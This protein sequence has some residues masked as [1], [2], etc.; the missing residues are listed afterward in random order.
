MILTL[1]LSFQIYS[2]QISQLQ[3]DSLYTKFIQLKAPELLPQTDQPFELTLEDRKCGFGI[4]NAIKTN[5]DFFSPEQMNILNSILS[6]PFL[7]TS[8]ISP[9]GF[10]RI[11]Y[12][13]AGSNTPAY[14]S[15]WTVDQ[16]VAEVAKALDSAYR[17]EINYLGFLSP[18]SDGNGGGDDKYDVY[19]QNQGGGFYGYTEWESKI[20]SVNWTSFMVIDNDYV[21]YYSTGLN[22]MRVT[23]AHEF[24]HSIQL[25]N[26][27]IFNDTNPFRSSDTYFYELTSTSMEEFVYDDVN[28]YYA[29]MSSYFN[30]TDLAFPGQ[31]GYNI[32]IW[33]IYLKDNFG[34][35]LLKR[36]WEL[37]P[38]I[39]AILA[40]NQS[41]N[42]LSTSF[43]RE[44]NKFGI[45]TYFTNFRRIPGKYFEEA[46][47]Y[48]IVIPKFNVQFPSPLLN[49]Q[50]KPTT[51]NFVRFNIPANNDTLVAVVTNADAFAANDNS[52]QLF[53]F[54]YTLYSDPNTGQRDLTEEYSSTFSVSNP[55]FWS[56]SEILNNVLVRQDTSQ[57]PIITS[58]ESFAF[59][60]PFNYLNSIY[61][62]GIFISFFATVGDELDF[63]VYSVGLEKVYSSNMRAT[64]RQTPSGTNYV[65]V[66]WNG[67]DNN[68][69]KLAS[70]VYIYVIKKGSEVVTGKVVI[71]NE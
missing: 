32:A 9:S 55:G 36:Q 57:Y 65:G 42:E 21:G 27:A 11:H 61:S 47:N 26:Y 18:P 15:G 44:F 48:P 30:N 58:N 43:P 70:G 71:F 25:G 56:V 66:N 59:P 60:N 41:L 62:D 67:L 64:Q 20:G 68:G 52:S 35:G 5:I 40:I 51:N 23:V 14:V 13:V 54:Q 10:F 12:D 46:A 63:N 29:Y 4:V 3:L 8:I 53:N 33:N 6:R 45:W 31:N 19:I 7:Q 2:Q 16:N 39:A 34:F 24:H 37:I 38:S 22:G 28:D 1:F 49:G 17:F 50:A 69:N